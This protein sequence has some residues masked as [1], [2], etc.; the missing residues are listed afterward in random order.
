MLFLIPTQKEDRKKNLLNALLWIL[1]KKKSE[2]VNKKAAGFNVFR[3]ALSCTGEYAQY[4]LAAAGTPATATDAQKKAVILAAMNTSLTR[5]NSIF[6]KDL[7]LHFSLI[8]N[9]DL[10]IF[11]DPATDPYTSVGTAAAQNTISS[12]ISESDYDMGHL[13]DKKDGTGV[14]NKGSICI[15][16]RKARGYTASNFPEGSTFD[17]DYVAHEMGAS[18]GCW[19]YLYDVCF[20]K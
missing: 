12:T 10:I 13:V 1:Q 15:N 14:A 9:N 16:G 3:L 17:I 6:E 19:S 18:D 5:M 20:S 4:H 11:L 7:S 2:S 8:A